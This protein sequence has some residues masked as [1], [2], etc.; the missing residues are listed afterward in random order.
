MIAK[1]G[2]GAHNLT[3]ASLAEA[4]KFHDK[5]CHNS[6]QLAFRLEEKPMNSEPA[7]LSLLLSDHNDL[8]IAFNYIPVSILQ[9]SK[10]STEPNLL[11]FPLQCSAESLQW[12]VKSNHKTFVLQQT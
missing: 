9:S 8:Q 1:V 10:L 5:L 12:A 2:S 11:P 7:N 3:H 6:R 4:S